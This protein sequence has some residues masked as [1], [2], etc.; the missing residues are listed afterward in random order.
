MRSTHVLADRLAEIIANFDSASDSV[1]TMPK[2]RRY[3]GTEFLANI[4]PQTR[5]PILRRLEDLVVPDMVLKAC[6][7][8]I[9]E[10]HRASLLRSHGV[11]PRHR[12]LT[13]SHGVDPRHRIFVGPPGN[14]KTS[15]AEAI[16]EA[17]ALPFLVVRYET[18]IGNTL[19]ETA[20][21]LTKMF[22]YA[23]TT[24]CVL[25]FDEFDSIGKERGDT[26]DASEIKRIVSSLITQ[27]E[28][29]PSYAV[30][31]AATNHPELL[32][33]AVWRRF[34]V[35][36]EL[37]KPTQADLATFMD[38]FLKRFSDS[39]GMSS[40]DLAKKLGPVSFSEAEQFWLDVMRRHTLSMGELPLKSLISDQLRLWSI[41]ANP[42]DGREAG[43][44]RTG[45]VSSGAA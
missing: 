39:A 34:Q 2:E 17:L 13:T 20:T 29:M 6:R 35:R 30:V 4:N 12:I 27:I 22:E 15:L 33:R 11:D 3:R 24:P 23:R 38:R 25:F 19:G 10:Q 43:E 45:T 9:E 21:R 40:S 14:G 5:A 28:A 32:D 7:E 42:Q 1:A 8:L 41:R 26:T 37:P 44:G 18:M 16:A 36:I 31:I